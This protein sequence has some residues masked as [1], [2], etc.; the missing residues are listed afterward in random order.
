MVTTYFKKNEDKRCFKPIVY[1]FIGI[2]LIICPPLMIMLYFM[3]AT[4]SYF[5][6]PTYLI[7]NGKIETFEWIR[8]LNLHILVNK[9]IMAFIVFMLYPVFMV[10]MAILAVLSIGIYYPILLILAPRICM[11]KR[12][13]QRIDLHY[14]IQKMEEK[15]NERQS[16]YAQPSDDEEKAPSGHEGM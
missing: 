5:I 8:K 14:M 16:R 10:S 3:S 1:F 4:F 9:L 11:M 2:F 12:K 15:H 7:V 13:R 6:I